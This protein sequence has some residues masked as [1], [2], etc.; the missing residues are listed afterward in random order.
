PILASCDDNGGAGINSANYHAHD[1]DTIANLVHDV[2]PL[3]GCSRRHGVGIYHSNAGGRIYDNIVFH[4]G[5]IGI[6]LWHA[7]TGVIVANN[8]VFSNVAAGIVVG[9]GDS[10]GNIVNDGT[11]VANNISL[12]NGIYG[13]QEFGFTGPRNLYI[14]NLV[15]Q[16]GKRGIQLLTGKAQGTIEA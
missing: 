14:K 8:T 6:Q 13:I 4:N 15:F 5:F 12:S 10:P 1:N 9:A 7:A 11:I 3:P 16:N 2:G